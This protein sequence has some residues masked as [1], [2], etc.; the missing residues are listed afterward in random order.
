MFKL[1]VFNILTFISMNVSGVSKIYLIR[2]AEV[3]IENPGWCNSNE[4]SN[5]K[6]LYNATSIQGFNRKS[7][8]HKIEKFETIDSIFSS[9]QLRAIET[10]RLLFNNQVKLII[11]DNLREFD[12]PVL[13][14]PVIKL[15]IKVWLSLS[16]IT[17]MLGNKDDVK[18][19]YTQKK[20]NLEIFSDEIINFAEINGV[21]VVIAHGML[22]RELAKILKNKGWDFKDKE[23][24]RNLSVNCL[25]K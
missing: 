5:Y 13:K 11:N 10:A 9:P 24:Y 19:S 6:K 4:A 18:L 21:S 25:V 23:G 14:W 2:H 16:L 17:W 20:R 12:Y 7:V 8:L 1:I 3:K 15:P 22:N